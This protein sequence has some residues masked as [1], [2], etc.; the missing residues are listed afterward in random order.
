MTVSENI[1]D[2][3]G[4]QSTYSGYKNYIKKNTDTKLPGFEEFTDEQMFF[5]SYGNVSLLIK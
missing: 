4:L 5:I 3:S 1:A 2:A